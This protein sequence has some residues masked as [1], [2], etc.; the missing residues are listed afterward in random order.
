MHNYKELKIWKKAHD[1]T[2]KIYERTI[3]FPKEEMYSWTN[4]LRSAAS[5]IPAT[6][7]E[8]FGNNAQLDYPYFLNYVLNSSNK[9]EYH[10]ILSKKF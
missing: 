9:V 2:F 6:I 1:F 7:E 8:G 10:S 4:Q 3:L 5:S